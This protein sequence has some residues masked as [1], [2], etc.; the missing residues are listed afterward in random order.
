[1][2][3][4]QSSNP[5]VLELNADHYIFPFLNIPNAR[6]LVSHDLDEML[7]A[8]ATNQSVSDYSTQHCYKPHT[9]LKRCAEWARDVWYNSLRLLR[10]IA[11]L[12]CKATGMYVE[13]KGWASKRVKSW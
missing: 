4:L 6:F 12:L 9:R 11:H 2:N 8:I 1:M 5:T 13:W 10:T 7:K 3:T